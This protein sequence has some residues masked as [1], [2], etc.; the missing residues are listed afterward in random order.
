M[1][2][3]ER[4]DH[5]RQIARTQGLKERERVGGR[6]HGKLSGACQFSAACL[7]EASDCGLDVWQD[8]R[9]N[10]GSDLQWAASGDRY[11]VCALLTSTGLLQ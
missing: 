8:E 7:V 4:V 10:S 5:E 2:V 11:S 1:C 6:V 3:R 9:I